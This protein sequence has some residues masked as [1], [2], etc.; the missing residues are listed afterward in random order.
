MRCVHPQ[1]RNVYLRESLDVCVQ[2]EY[3]H[4]ILMTAKENV[5]WQRWVKSELDKAPSEPSEQRLQSAQR[6]VLSGKTVLKVFV[7][8]AAKLNERS[9]QLF[10]SQ[11]CR[12]QLRRTRAMLRPF[13]NR[14]KERMQLRTMVELKEFEKAKANLQV[15]LDSLATIQDSIARKVSMLHDVQGALLALH[16]A[17]EQQEGLEVAALGNVYTNSAHREQLREW[18]ARLLRMQR[19]GALCLH[20]GRAR[21]LLLDGSKLALSASTGFVNAANLLHLVHC[22]PLVRTTCIVAAM[23]DYVIITLNRWT[24]THA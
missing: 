24:V 2:G 6:C 19:E 13:V 3:E 15:I 18:Q 12:D 23:H 14:V 7:G 4:G 9:P 10:A 21:A 20:Q 8:A 17:C 5:D 11:P 1:L 16:S 22:Q